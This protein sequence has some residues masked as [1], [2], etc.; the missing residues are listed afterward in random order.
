M[1]REYEPCTQGQPERPPDELQGKV[2]PGGGG[3]L[4]LFQEKLNLTL[5]I[6]NRPHYTF[7]RCE[8]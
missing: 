6:S 7:K 1:G 3:Q 2:N 5:F 4:A 8:A